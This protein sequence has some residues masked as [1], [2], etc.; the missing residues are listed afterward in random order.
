MDTLDSGDIGGNLDIEQDL[1]DETDEDVEENDEEA[2]HEDEGEDEDDG[3]EPKM[4][5]KEGMVSTLAE[6]V[7]NLVDDPPIVLSKQAKEMR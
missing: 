6:E 4:I 2:E 7:G 3:K 1:D 5:G